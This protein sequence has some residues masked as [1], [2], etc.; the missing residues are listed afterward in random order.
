LLVADSG[1]G[2]IR[3]VRF[4]DGYTV[5]LA[6]NT[7]T[8]TGAVNA[9][10]TNASFNQPIGMDQDANG[11]V[12]IAD[13]MTKTI[14]VMNLN[15]PAFGV[16][17]LVVTGTTF[18]HPTAVAFVG[19]NQ[20]W[21]ADSGNNAIKLI[22]LATPTT[23]S[24]TT[25]MGSNSQPPSS[26]T[27]VDSPFG[28]NARFNLPSGLLWIKGLG[29]LISDTGNNSIRLA[30]NNPTPAYG[31]TNYMVT[32]F[33]GTPGTPGSAD[34]PALS[35]TFHSPEGL[36]LDPAFGAFLVA[37]LASGSGKIRRVTT[38]LPPPPPPPP[39]GLTTTGSYGQITLT[40]TAATTVTNYNVK[41]STS[42][43]G[44]TTIAN[45]TG[46]SFTDTNLLDGMEYYYVVSALNTSGEGS[47]SLEA[48]SM[49]L[50]S[51]APTGLTV[52]STNFGQVDLIWSP[53]AGATSYNL[54]RSP[55]HGGPYTTTASPVTADYNDTSVVDGTTYYYVVSAVNTGGVNPTNSAEVS[56]TPP[57]SPVPD[58]QIGYVDNFLTFQPVSSAAFNNDVPIVIEGA[59]GSQTFYTYSNTP[60][61]ASLPDPTS[62]A[63]SA[64]N[65]PGGG[66]DP[67]SYTVAQILPDLSIKAIGEQPLHPNSAIVSAKFQFIVGNPQIFGTNAAQFTI[68]NIT[69]GAQMYYTTDGSDP[70]NDGSGTSIGPVL[71]GQTLSLDFGT[72]T[73]LLFNIRGFKANYHPSG[74]VSNLFLATSYAPNIINFGFGSGPGSSQYVASPGQSFFVPVGLSLLSSAPPIYGLQFNLTLTNLGSSAIDPG[75]I[76][77]ESLLGKPDVP[78]DGY[79]L[80]IPPWTF[81]SDIQPNNDPNA[82]LYQGDWYQSLE[83]A[84][85]NNEDLL[86]VGWLEVYGR[87]NLYNTLSQNL[88]TYPLVD[89]TEPSTTPSQM[90]IGSYSFGIPLNAGPGD[91]YQIQIGR[92]SATTFS[93]LNV[94]P[95]GTP[96]AIEAPVNTNLLGPGSV[97]ALKNVTIGQIKYLVGSIYPANW[98]N[99]G[100]FGSS[101]LANIDVI[102]VFDFAAYPIATPPAASDLYDALDSCGNIGVLDGNTGYLTNTIAY[103]YFTNYPNAIIDYTYT[104]DISG[105]LAN[106]TPGYTADFSTWIYMTTYYVAVPYVIT[107]IYLAPAVTNVVKTNYV[108]NITPPGNSTLF[109]GN[110][111]SIN[112]IAFGDGVL[113]VCD[114]YVTFRRSLDTNNLVW[115][116]RFWTNGVRVATANFAPVIQ[117][118]VSGLSNGKIL[119][120]I[121]ESNSTPISITNTPVVNFACGD[122][123]TTA[124]NT[125]QIPVTASVVGSYPLR[126]AMLNISVV[127]LDGSPALTTPISFSPGALGA[128][129]S[130]FTASSGNGN[131]AAAWLDSTITGISSSAIIGALTITIPASATSLSSYAVH[132]DH[133]SGSPNGIAS[134]PRHTLTGLITLSSRTNSSYGD[135]IPDTW[136]LRWFGTTNNL[137]SV[138][139]ACPAGDG[140]NNWKKYV[141][142]VDPNTHNDF[143][144]LNPNTPHSGTVK[145]IFWPTVSGKQYAVLSSA[146]LFQDNWNTNAIVTGNG[147]NMEFDDNSTGTVKFYRVLILP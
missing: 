84:D 76:D 44:E 138:S 34:G 102:R 41:R 141:A 2:L 54:K 82:F 75:T 93:G 89:G 118:S 14:R 59:A 99:A 5:T 123:Q 11:N 146:S 58:P 62:S 57:M 85:T 53:S 116:Q 143:P 15:D 98:Y 110:D 39:V 36:C 142:G 113:D 7:N 134:F 31:A 51:P 10:G 65:Y 77:F 86:G 124:G 71:S 33:A 131:Y 12:Y 115:F 119:P 108:I 79:Y 120:A 20:L 32:T 135:G 40:W 109:N 97:N 145:S 112:Q 64:Q 137:L 121:G 117:S 18:S 46:T 16:T 29:L 68:T 96:V 47:N 4:S 125:I 28:P 144:N 81:V 114:V 3:F 56:A 94:N 104:Y 78:F 8:P 66:L 130:G 60:V 13:E 136:R 92:P 87:T 6:G 90:V 133:A 25:Y 19:T 80:P 127:P 70:T 67:T 72:S 105:H 48:A 129:S 101:N 24:L 1:N 45:T 61:I 74:T 126:V 107:N 140:I 38:G 147:A 83:F 9:A 30:T 95:Y 69:S 73:N 52:V 106:I 27:S 50:F 21:V 100:D 128:P 23:G 42:S 139:N 37:D 63:N 132:F 17:N 88:L 26:P 103:P 22:T 111:T 43:G 49:S 122:I 55:S 35:A 91:V